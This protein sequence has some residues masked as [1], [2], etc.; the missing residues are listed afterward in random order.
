MTYRR[1]KN[2]Y[3]AIVRDVDTE[4]VT[5]AVSCVSRFSLLL[6]KK[7]NSNFGVLKVNN[8]SVVEDFRID[9]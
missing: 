9:N 3:R 7:T 5:Y 6:L 8:E 4:V 2:D 1:L